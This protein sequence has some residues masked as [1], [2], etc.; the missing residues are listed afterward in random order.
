MAQ[1]G[2][3]TTITDKIRAKLL[4]LFD[5]VNYRQ[6]VAE[7]TGVHENTVGN[8]MLRGHSN[9]KVVIALLE[10]GKEMKELKQ[11]EAEKVSVLTKQL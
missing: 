7:R 2:N 1:Q 5:G 4:A 9:L 3:N 11:A 8:V 6:I 10:L